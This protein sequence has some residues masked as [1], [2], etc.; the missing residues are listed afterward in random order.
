MLIDA[1]NH[2]WDVPWPPLAPDPLA[3]EATRFLYYMDQNQ[4]Q[5]A[6]VV[7]HLDEHDPDNNRRALARAAEFP[8]RFKVLG[9][10]HLNQPEALAKVKAFL[11]EPHLVGISYY[12]AA[13]DP[14]EWMRPGP[15]FDT[16]AAHALAVNLNLQPHQHGKLRQ[17]ARAYPETPFLVCH[18]GAPVRGGEPNPEWEEVL[19]SA[20][21]PN[22][23]MKISG[24]AYYSARYWEYPYRDVLPYVQRIA[25]AY[26]PERML[27]GSDHPVTTRFMTYRQSIEVVRT[28]CDFLTEAERALVLGENARRVFGLE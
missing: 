3:G 6:I 13:D 26:G 25:A 9:N 4:V 23:L 19:R 15:L 18:L 24:F 1:H 20:E 28:H 8:G 27:W 22:L 7:A 2:I 17:V 10:V 16:L 5:T 11:G 21:V 12:P 14:C